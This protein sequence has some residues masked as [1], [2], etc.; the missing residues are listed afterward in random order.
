MQCGCVRA[1]CSLVAA[2]T[3]LPL[4]ADASS[5]LSHSSREAPHSVSYHVSHCRPRAPTA[6]LHPPHL[7]SPTLRPSTHLG[8][9][10][11]RTLGCSAS[12]NSSL[13]SAASAVRARCLSLYFSFRSAVPARFLARTRVSQGAESSDASLTSASLSSVG[14]AT[15]SLGA[16]RKLYAATLAAKKMPA[17]IQGPEKKAGC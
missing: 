10:S 9:L 2:R 15:T 14:E 6:P 12:L 7:I 3:P 11:L 4:A 17:W 1:D 5:L 8:Y 16:G 13:W